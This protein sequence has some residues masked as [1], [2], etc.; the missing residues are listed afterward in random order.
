M[1]KNITRSLVSIKQI[2]IFWQENIAYTMWRSNKYL[3][4]EDFKQ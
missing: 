3:W 4:R 2:I 1:L